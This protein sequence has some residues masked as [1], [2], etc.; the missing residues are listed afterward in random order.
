MVP[1]AAWSRIEAT[2]ET[3]AMV[4]QAAW[5]RTEATEETPAMVPQAA[6]SRI[7]ATEETPAM[8]PQAAW[9]IKQADGGDWTTVQCDAGQKVIGGGCKATNPPYKFQTSQPQGDDGWTCGGHGGDKSV[10]AVC[11]SSLTATIK[12]ADG[13]EWTTVHCD[14]GKKVIAGGCKATNP[15][16][17]FQTN[18]PEGDGGWTCGGHADNKSVWAICSS[19]LTPTIKHADGG[20]WTTLQCDAGQKVIS[21]GCKATNP[22]YEFQT[23]QPEGD[24]GWTCGGHG[25]EK[26]VWAICSAPQAVGQ[27][28]A[29]GTTT[30]AAA[31]ATK[32]AADDADAAAK[33]AFEDEAATKKQA[34]DDAAA[35]AAAKKEAADQVDAAKKAEAEAAAK[36]AADKAA[37]AARIA[38]ETA[39]AAKKALEDVVAN[40]KLQAA[41]EA[42]RKAEE[43][44]AAKKVADK[45]A[46]AKQAAEKA[47]A[48]KTKA[49][50]EAAA[51]AAAKAKADAE[52]DAQKKAAEEALA[53]QA[54]DAAALA[55]QQADDAAAAEKKAADEAAAAEA[56]ADANSSC[57]PMCRGGP[58]DCSIPPCAGCPQCNLQASDGAFQATAAAENESAKPCAPYCVFCDEICGLSSYD[59]PCGIWCKKNCDEN[60]GMCDI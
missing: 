45:Q 46:A 51:A 19:S 27:D 58:D 52:A 16:Y 54:A 48:A 33:N 26:S 38:Q 3:P 4:P 21:G 36:K 1:Q 32:K 7:E 43:A 47:A 28:A 9:I 11:S 18:Q 44:A 24:G 2:E 5:S 56:E 17:K 10:W 25:G 15:P 23:S 37:S 39:A 57:G 13:G 12:H 60:P 34:A 22:P 53:K 49:D 50:E 42:K 6:W 40:K 59:Q 29:I 14:A 41:A 8:V 35:A 30:A 31:A 55:K 20:D